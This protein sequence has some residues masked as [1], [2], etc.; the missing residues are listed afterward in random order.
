MNQKFY[1][2][3][4][5][6]FA[7][8]YL[9]FALPLIAMLGGCNGSGSQATATRPTGTPI[10]PVAATAATI[11]DLP[12]FLV[13]LGS[14]TASNTVSIKSRVD[15]Q[16]VQVNFREGQQVSKGQLLAVLDSRP[17]QVQLAQAQAVLFRDQAQLK[18]AKLNAQRFKDLLKDSGAV[19]QQ[20]VDTQSALVDQFEG[21]V[22]NDQAQID[23][24]KLQITYCHITAPIS[25]RVGLRL[26]DAGNIIH[27]SDPNPLLVITQ[28][29]PMAVL[30]SL[31]EDQLPTVQQ[32]MK[33]GPLRVDAYGRD[34]L[35]K[36]AT[37]QLLTLDNEIDQTTGT[38]RL[39]AIFENKDNTLLS[40]QFVNV[41]LLLEQRK[42]ATVIPL[43]AIQKGPQGSFVYAV[44]S[45]KTVE[46]RPVTIA[47]T[48]GNLV[49]IRQGVAAG[50]LVVT[51]G[52]DKLQTGS[53]VEVHTA[54]PPIPTPGPNTPPG[55][56]PA[57]GQAS[58]HQR[59]NH[60]P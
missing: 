44:K 22:R 3:S 43:V 55:M 23:N 37:G 1:R 56:P 15:G 21:A 18:D 13:G 2:N 26:V 34:D 54:P 33:S 38:G 42:N 53:K 6:S 41:H 16:L 27:A 7:F 31:P 24:A 36:I 46:I 59:G 8:I 45:D 9:V 28:L 10:V 19:S 60:R 40:N 39:K 11:Q 29:Q 52:Q 57:S 51:D 47:L 35:T 17:F 30:F 5:N 14:A 32:H 4:A 50:D 48:Q 25:G 12:V 58:G 49:A 20:Q